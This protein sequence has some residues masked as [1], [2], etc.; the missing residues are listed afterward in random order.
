MSINHFPTKM[1]SISIKHK[2]NW[3]VNLWQIIFTCRLKEEMA[4]DIFNDQI[5]SQSI[6]RDK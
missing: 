5:F 2:L 4:Y 1:V 6:C 3:Q